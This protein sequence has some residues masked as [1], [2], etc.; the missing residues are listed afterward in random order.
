MCFIV[1]QHN[2]SREPLAGMPFSLTFPNHARCFIHKKGSNEHS[3]SPDVP[4]KKNTVLQSI[5]STDAHTH[6]QAYALLLLLC[7][8]T[9]AES[10]VSFRAA[11]SNSETCTHVLLSL[12][13]HITQKLYPTGL[14]RSR[15]WFLLSGWF[16]RKRSVSSVFPPLGVLQ[17]CT[18]TSCLSL[19]AA[20][21]SRWGAQEGKLT[22]NKCKQ[23]DTLL[24][25]H[26]II[27]FF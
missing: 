3:P 20:S 18:K 9:D 26:I 23:A 7:D 2:T 4:L 10:H 5:F 17:L 27:I 19:G 22:P 1:T 16:C 15:G 6:L 21:L 25:I 8:E 14:M 12:Q 11:A 13:E 24:I